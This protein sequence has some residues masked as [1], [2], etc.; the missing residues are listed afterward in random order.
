MKGKSAVIGVMA[1]VF[2]SGCGF[3]Q[4]KPEVPTEGKGTP[5]STPIYQYAGWVIA[6][7]SVHNHTTFSDGCFMP[8]DLVRQARKQGIA[9]LA[10]TDHREGEICLGNTRSKG[11]CVDMGGIDTKKRGYKKYFEAISKLA[12]ESKSPLILLGMEVGPY[13]WNTGV[14][15][16]F[17]FTAAHWHFT[18]YNINDVSVYENMPVRKQLMAFREPDP[19]LKPYIEWVD[20]MIKNGALVFQAHPDSRDYE[21]YYTA[22]LLAVAPIQLTDNIPNLTGVAI[23][24]SGLTYVGIP[25]GEWDTAQLQYMAGLRKAPLWG[26]GESDFECPPDSLRHGTTMFYVKE[27]TRENVLAA[28]QTGKMIALMGDDFQDLYVTEFSVG[29]GKP[30]EKKIM[31]GES[32]KLNGPAV[33]NFSLNKDAPEQE[34]RLVRNG[35]VIFST[36]SARFEYRDEEAGKNKDKIFYRV[37]VQGRGVT[38]T[39][40]GNR[41]FTNPIF[42]GWNRD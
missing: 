24:P 40:K 7:A 18:V 36:K 22:M 2:L 8:E 17:N 31:F 12:A 10:I 30:A 42:V 25:G 19:G 3:I 26:W 14:A 6:R 23:I 33:V 11:L 13:F 37:E 28:M 39:E 1:F 15:P 16:Y 20:Y 29:D 35:R 38:E 21:K 4:R 34:V 9:V 27:L 32:V 41:L 5:E